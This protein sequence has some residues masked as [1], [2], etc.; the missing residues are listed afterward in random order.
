VFQAAVRESGR[1]RP[2]YLAAYRLATQANSI[3]D[4]ILAGAQQAEQ[5]RAKEQDRLEAALRQAESSYN[6]AA[7]Y[8][9]SRRRGVGRAARTRLVEAEG[10]LE[11]AQ[12][13]ADTDPG[14]ALVEATRAYNLA[15]DA[16]AQAKDDFDDYDGGGVFGG[17][18]RGGG[19]FPFPIIVGGGGFGGGQNGGGWGGTPWGSGG[20][21]GGWGG[22]GFGG[23][24]SG[25]GGFGGSG[26]GGRW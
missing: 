4:E 14:A 25:G 9:S 10:H 2:D 8:I 18:R 17:R 11:Q 21:G 26:G 16:Y 15:E 6:R 3:A 1:P 12:R 24:S 13:L 7:D 19:I 5:R 22:G 20:G 23:G